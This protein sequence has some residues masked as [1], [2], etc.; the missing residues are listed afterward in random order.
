MKALE[1]AGE[2]IAPGESRTVRI[3]LARAYDRSPMEL[4]IKA[5]RGKREGPTLFITAAIHGDELGGI[6]IIRR[7]VQR[8]A[9]RNL[10]GTLLL[11]PVVNVFGFNTK[12]R[13]LPDGRDLNRSFPGSTS[14]SLAS[15]IA[16]VITKELVENSDFG[17][18]LHTGARERSNVPQIRANLDDPKTC[19]LAESFGVPI[20]IN[21]AIRDGS[22]R[23][24]A[25]NH[26]VPVLLYEAGEALRYDESS[27]RKGLS[28]I[29]NVMGL[30][31]MIKRKPSGV[32]SDTFHAKSSRWIRA[33]TS[34]LMRS[35]IRQ[36]T[37]VKKGQIIAVISDPYGIESF[38]QRS[39]F[40]G[41]VIGKLQSP[42]VNKGD[43]IFHV[44][45]FEE[46]NSVEDAFEEYDY[47]LDAVT[48][49]KYE[50]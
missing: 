50:D 30:L 4:S 21:A 24:T 9:L 13:Y 16:N 3:N 14:G 17:I 12:S 20:L 35:S 39:P 11:A 40:T 25:Q 1:I 36:G 41:I 33:T 32:N 38:E 10:K 27:I 43:A 47:G 8:K 29:L 45:S 34:G 5:L 46:I 19:E 22:L 15:Q 7:L 48:S 42:L 18:D 31:G 2:S 23:E 44:A 6:E 49:K 37:K 26:G 28:G